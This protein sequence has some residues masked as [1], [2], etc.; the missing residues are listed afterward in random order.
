MVGCD[1]NGNQQNDTFKME[2]Q[3]DL[4]H[5]YLSELDYEMAIA[6]YMEILEVDTSRASVYQGITEAY[7]L[8]GDYDNALK[9]AKEGYENT[10]DEALAELVK[11]IENLMAEE[12][13]R[14]AAEEEAARLAAEEEAAR[15]AAEEEAARLAAEEE[16]ARLAAEEEAARL[17]AEEEAARLAAEEEAASRKSL[18]EGHYGDGI[19]HNTYTEFGLAEEDTTYLQQIIDNAKAGSY[20]NVFA[21]LQSDKQENMLVRLGKTYSSGNGGEVCIAY[22]EYKVRATTSRGTY[23]DTRTIYLI[24]INDEKG[25]IFEYSVTKDSNGN[26]YINKNSYNNDF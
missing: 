15:L 13:A 25:Y 12:A 26:N 11:Q 18:F 14:L 19:W 17:A 8:K 4:G 22:N 7:M 5:K 24:P 9:Y 6:T 2:E 23:N 21:L 3:L 1:A 16:A 10:G 20:E